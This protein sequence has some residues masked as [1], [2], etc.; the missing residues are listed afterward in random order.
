MLLELVLDAIDRGSGSQVA[1]TVVA[2]ADRV[3]VMIAWR[4]A[5][6]AATH[7]PA[8]PPSG[9]SRVEVSRRLADLQGVGLFVEDGTEGMTTVLTLPC[10]PAP[11]VLVVDD[12]AD[13]IHM[14]RHYLEGVYEV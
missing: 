13:V 6:S 5:A 9:E 14:F 12:N 2:S 1:L 8:V 7:Q 10:G 11:I 4:G 3:R